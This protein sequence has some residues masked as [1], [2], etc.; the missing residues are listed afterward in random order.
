MAERPARILTIAGSDSGGGAG[1]QADIKTITMLGGHAMTAITAIT[2]QNSGG[3]DA[4]QVLGADMVIAQID[5][6]ARD[7]GLD[8]I[9]IGMLGSPEIAEALADWLS[10]FPHK[11]DSRVRGNDEAPVIFDPVM[12]ASSGAVL[13][14]EATIAAFKRLMGC[15]TLVTPNLPELGALGGEAAVLE[16]APA[17][18]IKGGHASGETVTDRLVTREGEIAR[19]DDPRID[20]PHTHGTGCTL[21]S[22]IATLLGQGLALE[23]AVERA[24]LFVRL[25]LRDAPA[26]VAVNGPM[27]HQYVRN[28]ALAPGWNLNQI[29]L[30][31]TDYAA[32]VT[33]YRALGLVQIV[34][35]PDNGYA[36]FEAGNGATLSIHVGEAGGGAMAYLECAD[37]DARVLALASEGFAIDQMPRDESWGW[38]EARLCDP[39]GNVLCLYFGGENRRY[40]PWRIATE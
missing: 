32:S 24:R 2:A 19:W 28:D 37:L 22:A 13:A 21:S 18:L 27:G 39:A 7:F 11:R 36:R 31:A 12:I 17:L 4:V 23:Q 1:I 26:L 5:A 33:F 38:R 20:S 9:K 6:V 25:A 35:S 16:L 15:A 34:D 30:G 40:P 8:A 10:S 14:D 3:V 29:T